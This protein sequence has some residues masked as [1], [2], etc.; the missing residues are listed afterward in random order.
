M[1]H[2]FKQI[3]YLTLGRRPV[4]SP[5]RFS[6]TMGRVRNSIDG[7]RTCSSSTGS[8]AAA[9][10]YRRTPLLLY[11]LSVFGVSELS[12]SSTGAASCDFHHERD[13]TLPTHPVGLAGS[14]VRPKTFCWLERLEPRV[15]VFLFASP[16]LPA[17]LRHGNTS[18]AWREPSNMRALFKVA[19]AIRTRQLGIL[20]CAGLWFGPASGSSAPRE[21]R[22]DRIKYGT[23]QGRSRAG[24]TVGAEAESSLRALFKVRVWFFLHICSHGLWPQVDVVSFELNRP[25]G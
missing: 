4:F 25:A 5:A 18:V 1:Q 11:S 3:T 8:G 24:W 19:R 21:A 9:A 2:Q 10:Q 20:I 15:Y 16:L 23:G 7:L 22:R 12:M 13:I 14:G 17:R 6:I